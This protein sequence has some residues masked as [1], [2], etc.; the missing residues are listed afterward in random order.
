MQLNSCEDQLD[1]FQS[2]VHDALN[3]CIPMRT[4]KQHPKDKPWIT[5]VNKESIKKRQ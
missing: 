3:S 4:E 2:V 5:P 1:F